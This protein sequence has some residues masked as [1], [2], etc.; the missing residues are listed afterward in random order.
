[1]NTQVV[2]FLASTLANSAQPLDPLV[3]DPL[4]FIVDYYSWQR[5]PG[6]PRGVIW[7]RLDGFAPD[8]GDGGGGWANATGLVPAGDGDG[9]AL[10]ATT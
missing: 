2:G 10:V 8:N 1:M 9:S 4:R 7:N 5:Q 6:G 3:N